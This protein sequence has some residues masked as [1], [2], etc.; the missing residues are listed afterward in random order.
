[1]MREV[2]FGS[3]QL[4]PAKEENKT[5]IIVSGEAF[6]KVHEDRGKYFWNKATSMMLDES[7]SRSLS[8]AGGLFY[9][10][11]RVG[12]T[13]KDTDYSYNIVDTTLELSE[14]RVLTSWGEH[15]FNC[16]LA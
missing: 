9:R 5:R 11:I 13:R 14:D 15:Q 7:N 2:R 6:L 12:E 10:G 1:M 8:N 3:V 16:A 4:F